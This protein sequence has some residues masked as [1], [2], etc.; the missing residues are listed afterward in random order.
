MYRNALYEKKRKEAKTKSSQTVPDLRPRGEG[1]SMRRYMEM[2]YSRDAGEVQTSP[3]PKADSIQPTASDRPGERDQYGS[4]EDDVGDAMVLDS[5]ATSHQDGN[6]A[7]PFSLDT[8]NAF[9]GHRAHK[10][11]DSPNS[12]RSGR[13]R[14]LHS[15]YDLPQVYEQRQGS[16]KRRRLSVEELSSNVT[17]HI[18]EPASASVAFENLIIDNLDDEDLIPALEPASPSP[19]DIML[20]PVSSDSAGPE[21]PPSEQSTSPPTA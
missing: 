18:V 21:T 8:M 4:T 7:N 19:I 9:V 5:H 14:S 20:S 11:S 3:A 10:T 12:T 16:P 13:R 1:G 6:R 17:E 15:P 2:R